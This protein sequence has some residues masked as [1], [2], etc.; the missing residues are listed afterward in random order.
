MRNGGYILVDRTCLKRSEFLRFAKIL[1]LIILCC[2]VVDTGYAKSIVGSKHDLSVRGPGPTK[3]P[4][5]RGVCV[6]C[7]AAHS[8]AA[9]APLWNRY[10]SGAQYS[11]YKSTT[12]KA[13]IGQP[14]GSSKLCL[15]C[16]DGTVA[17]GMVRSRKESIRFAGG[18]TAMPKGDSNIGTDLADDHPI[19]FRY[20][21]ELCRLNSNLRDPNELDGPVSLEGGNTVQCSSC[22]NAHDD[23]FGNFLVMDNY[24]SALCLQCHNQT[25]WKGSDHESSSANWNGR[26]RAPWD[27]NKG[28]TVQ[29]NGC[30]SC[31]RPHNAGTKQR[32]L[33]Y[34][35]EEDNC[36]PCHNGNVASRN[37]ESDFQKRSKHD[38]LATLGV[39][40]PLEDLLNPVAR[41]VECND[42]H[43]PHAVRSVT[44][45][46]PDASGAL[47]AVKGVNSAGTEVTAVKYQYELCFR[48]HGDSVDK[49]PAR[50]ERQYPQTNVRI[51]FDQGNTSYHPV[52]AQ[53]KNANVPSL[54]SPMDENSIIF[55]T[56]CHSSNESSN[57]ADSGA[58]H[59]SIYTPILNRRLVLTDY[60]A[61]SA[62]AY[63]LCY[64]CHDRTS[65]LG[66]Q[67]FKYHN[68]HISDERTAC[69][70]CH[71]SH[72]SKNNTHLINFNVQYVSANSAGELSWRDDGEFAGSCSLTCHNKEHDNLKYPGVNITP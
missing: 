69:T 62:A 9:N 24:A 33:N 63:A 41:H 31:H 2:Y 70:T 12:I 27:R 65:I 1:M 45:K 35:S 30:G 20:D 60:D 52:E 51:E 61:E 50:V 28:L 23:A 17:L 66:D 26:G 42:C 68:M 59:G 46:A 16:H 54:I 10:D 67:S 14:T 18:I 3:S 4:F 43:N 34:A 56:D 7:H 44:A 64:K 15:S 40:D 55:C 58:P 29:A 57:G 11:V 25:Y 38:I 5:E 72:A 19:S 32:L 49:G 21:K 39:H 37:V 8:G 6:F 36:F 71:D 22:H 47:Y 53:G 48:C 13:T